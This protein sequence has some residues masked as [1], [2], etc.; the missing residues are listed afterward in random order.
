MKTLIILFSFIGFMATTHAQEVAKKPT[1]QPGVTAKVKSI[2][3]A[4]SIVNFQ[5]E[6]QY[7]D[8]L[9]TSCKNSKC[10]PSESAKLVELGRQLVA[11]NQDYLKKHGVQNGDAETLCQSKQPIFNCDSKANSLMRKMCYSANGYSL[12]VWAQK[13]QSFKKRMP[14]SQNK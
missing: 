12:K 6:R 3:Q 4:V 5:T 13:E 8:M 7:M 2:L 9:S 14:A 11:C 1:Q 10:N